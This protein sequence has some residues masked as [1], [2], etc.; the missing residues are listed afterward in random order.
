EMMNAYLPDYEV[1]KC[2]FE[3]FDITPETILVGHSC[4]G[5]FLVRWLSEHKDVK[6][7]KVVLVAPWLDLEDEL[8]NNFF[9]FEADSHLVSRTKGVTVFNSDNDDEYIQKS[10]LKIRTEILQVKYI[11]FHNY[12]HFCVGDIHSEAFPELLEEVLM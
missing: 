3:R 7:G 5:G 6:V 2:E 11:E 8:S 1:W 10:V 12:G 9:K 4:G